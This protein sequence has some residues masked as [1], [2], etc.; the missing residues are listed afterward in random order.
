MPRFLFLNGIVPSPPPP[1]DA[2]LDPARVVQTLT[3]DPES[4][5]TNQRFAAD[6]LSP[7]WINVP[8]AMESAASWRKWTS[9]PAQYFSA[10]KE[11]VFLMKTRTVS[12]DQEVDTWARRGDVYLRMSDEGTGIYIYFDTENG[13]NPTLEIGIVDHALSPER[14]GNYHRLWRTVDLSAMVDNYKRYFTDGDYFTFGVDGFEIYAK[15]NGQEFIRFKDYRVMQEGRVVLGQVGAEYGFRKTTVRLET[16]KQIYSDYRNKILDLR[17]FGLQDT[18]AIG[19]ITAG[20]NQLKLATPSQFKGGDYVIVETGEETG[21]GIP[22]SEGVGGTW[23]S[24]SYAT[25]VERDQDK[26]QPVDTYAWIESDGTIYQWNGKQWQDR[27]YWINTSINP[28]VRME[29]YYVKRAVPLALRAK[30][31]GVSSDGL[32]LT[33]SANAGANASNA[34]VHFDNAYVINKLVRSP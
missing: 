17:D 3:L 27:S 31:L 28:P 33:L 4:F 16:P 23:P 15:Y 26:F 21:Q 34:N 22:G 1:P 13:A 14:K 20:S 12:R 5:K 30:I 18:S 2:S 32:T 9:R 19:S 24:K 11:S 29:N 8:G 10:Q 25:A 7:D 6:S